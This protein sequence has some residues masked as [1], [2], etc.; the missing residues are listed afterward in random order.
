MNN[1]SE[2]QNGYKV[3]NYLKYLENRI[4]KIE[5][6]LNISPPNEEEKS[7][8]TT[9]STAKHTQKDES[10][11]FRIG[12]YWLPKVG[13]V[14]LSIGIIFLLTFPYQNLS[15]IIPSLFGYGL[16]AGIFGLSYYWRESFSYIPCMTT[17]SVDLIINFDL[18]SKFSLN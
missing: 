4:S 14:V 9:P 8:L 11:E 1:S 2:N 10:L 18:C 3:H 17:S 6:R 16:A 7:Y 13:I 15:P 12:Q 5:S